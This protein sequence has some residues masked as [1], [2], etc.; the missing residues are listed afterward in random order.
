[1]VMK[2]YNDHE[3]TVFYDQMCGQYV[4][5]IDGE[6]VGRANDVEGVRVVINRNIGM[7]SED[8]QPKQQIPI[9]EAMK[10]AR[11]RKHMKVEDLAT[12]ANVAARSLHAYERGTVMPNVY[13][14]ADLA[15]ALGISIDEY[16]G[17]K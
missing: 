9:S 13:T 1:M 6:R 16:I 14:V 10:K 4:I 7:H 2:E 11:Q 3:V 17:R 8:G 12:A 15:S 5:E